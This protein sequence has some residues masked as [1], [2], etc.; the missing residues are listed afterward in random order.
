MPY[1][2][3]IKHILLNILNSL[4]VFHNT[5]YTQHKCYE[6]M[7]CR[8]GIMTGRIKP[9]SVQHRNFCQVFST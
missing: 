8:V 4:Q 6:V 5:Q 9:L 2:H 3:I 7:L 1:L